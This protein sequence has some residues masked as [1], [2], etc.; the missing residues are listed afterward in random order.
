[1]WKRSCLRA[2]RST[3]S[4]WGHPVLLGAIGAG[5]AFPVEYLLRGRDAAMSLAHGALIALIG[6]LGGL[7]VLFLWNL[8][9]APYRIERDR[10]KELEAELAKREAPAGLEG[11][12]GRAEYALT[13]VVELLAA[14]PGREKLVMMDLQRAI[15]KGDLNILQRGME[16]RN[17]LMLLRS[18]LLDIT[19]D[20]PVWLH[21]V[22]ISRAELQRFLPGRGYGLPEWLRDRPA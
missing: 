21:K 20:R 7:I 11:Y 6:G 18:P 14:L 1:M 9:C 2:W 12:R 17:Y 5:L 22:M 15:A 19:Q 13:E 10:R 4:S 16:E 3:W 8:A